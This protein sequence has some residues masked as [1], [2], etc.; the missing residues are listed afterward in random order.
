MQSLH[1]REQQP[2]PAGRLIKECP[3]L[4]YRKILMTNA[5]VLYHPP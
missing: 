2:P 5:A 4:A 1:K 3:G